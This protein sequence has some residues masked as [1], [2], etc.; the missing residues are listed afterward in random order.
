MLSHGFFLKGYS[1]KSAI[2]EHEDVYVENGSVMFSPLDPIFVD[3]D[4]SVFFDTT[5]KNA[6]MY[7]DTDGRVFVRVVK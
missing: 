3:D 7:A 2:G 5:K 4:G 6:Y 1:G